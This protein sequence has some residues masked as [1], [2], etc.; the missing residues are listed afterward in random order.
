MYIYRVSKELVHPV[1]YISSLELAC[2]VHEARHRQD[3][4]DD[5]EEEEPELFVRL[6]VF[7]S[8]KLDQLTS[9][10]ILLIHIQSVF[11]V[12]RDVFS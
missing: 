7:D 8:F 11:P 9:Y 3:R 12:C 10:F 6:V 4:D 5:E 2:K 1:C